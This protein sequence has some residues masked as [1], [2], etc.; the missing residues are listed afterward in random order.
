MATNAENSKALD[1]ES[2]EAS[3]SEG[4]IREAAQTDKVVRGVNGGLAPKARKL[5][6]LAGII[7]IAPVV[8]AA[9]YMRHGLASRNKKAAKQSDAA[10]IGVS[11]ATTVQKDMLSDQARTGL[12]LGQDSVSNTALRSRNTSA[13]TRRPLWANTRSRPAGS[14]PPCSNSSLTPICRG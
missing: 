11:P 2:V 14:S 12:D 7:I 8:L 1:L 4:E 10:K 6:P 9:A 5:R 3:Q 13:A